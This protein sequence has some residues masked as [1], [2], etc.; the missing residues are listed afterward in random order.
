MSENDKRPCPECNDQDA[1][2]RRGFMRT[3]GGTATVLAAGSMAAPRVWADAQPAPA[4]RTAKPA[5]ALIQE[6]FTGLSDEQKRQVVMPWN[7]GAAQNQ[8]PTRMRM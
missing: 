4:N 5:E 1:M 6:L 2:D 3:V 8:L 7:H